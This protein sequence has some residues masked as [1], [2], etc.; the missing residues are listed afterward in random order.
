MMYAIPKIEISGPVLPIS[1]NVS[2]C[3]DVHLFINIAA[4]D[5]EQTIGG[6]KSA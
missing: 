6:W 3:S 1:E 2:P 5:T 4:R